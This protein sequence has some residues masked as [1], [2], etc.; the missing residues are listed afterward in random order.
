MNWKK[1]ARSLAF[2]LIVLLVLPDCESQRGRFYGG[3]RVSLNLAQID[4]D[5]IFGYNRFGLGAGVFGAANLGNKSELHLEFLY[6]V[7]GSRYNSRSLQYVAY[8]L[9]YIDVPLLF[10]FK[11]WFVEEHKAN[12][13]KM[14]FQGGVYF[15]RLFKSASENASNLDQQFR[16]NDLG[17]VLGFT[18]YTNVHVG[19]TGRF[20]NSVLPLIKYVNSQGEEIKMISYFISLGLTY[21]FN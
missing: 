8:K 11:D 17:W 20:T 12:Y 3:G 7:R 15:G 9:K 2:L 18:Y 19:L 5:G 13:Y 10:T 21:R 16:K 4:G 14:H 6:N 1:T